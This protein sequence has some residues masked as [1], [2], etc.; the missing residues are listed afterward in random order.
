MSKRLVIVESPAKC[1]TILKYLGKDYIVMASLGHVRDLPTFRLGV[2]LDNNFQPTYQDLKDKKKVIK[3]LKATAKKCEEI[4]IATDPDR[5][6]EAIA[7]HIQEAMKS[8]KNKFKRI[9]FN[10]ITKNAVQSAI[11]DPRDINLNLVNAQQARRILDRLI[12]YKLSPI[13]SKKIRKGLSAGRVQSVSAKLVCD[14]EEE[15]SKFVPVE[16]W[17]ITSELK[18]PDNNTFIATLFAENDPKN[19]LEVP[20]QE[21]A[22]K[23]VE[24]L[25][26]SE[27]SI[28]SI[29]KKE[30]NRNPAPPFITSTLQQ[31]ASRKLNWS[32][33]KT[34][35]V[36]QQ[37]YEG[38]DVDGEA[39][40]LITYMRTD[41]FRISNEARDAAKSYIIKKY[42]KDYYPESPRFYK[43][44]KSAQD[45]HEAIRPTYFELSPDTVSQKTTSDQAK[46]YK[47]IWDRFMASQ[48]SSAK[49]ERTT[50][51]TECAPYFLKTTGNILLFNGF[52]VLYE[53][54]KDDHD[55]DEKNALLPSITKEDSLSLKEVDAQQKFTQPPARYTEAS[56]I[57]EMEEQGI[58][59]PSTY[60]PTLS[61]IQDRGYVQKENKSLLPTELGVLVNGKLLEFFSSIIDVSFTSDMENKLDEIMEGKHVWQEIL[62]DF[63]EPFSAMLEKANEEMEKVNLD[64]PS[65]EVCEK[66]NSPMVIKSGRFGDFLACTSFPDCKNTKSILVELGVNCPDCDSPLIEKKTKRGKPFYGCSTYPKCKFA[67]WTKPVNKECPSCKNPIMTEKKKKGDTLS[68]ICPK[69]K[70]ETEK[71]D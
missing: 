41:S 18:T 48:M 70:H 26:S 43:S 42:C 35:I 23:V 25:K 56:L 67:L 30:V 32:T 69:C 16:Y 28:Y 45:A 10:E 36:A 38:I 19:K 39:T 2:D 49:L 27:Y 5:E 40:G 29:E 47:L 51:I 24:T 17:V 33:K 31:D 58:G 7:W 8:D 65:D 68:Y 44:K 63:Y 1:K 9:V 15:I 13:L 14:R 11:K 55:K 57:K 22:D 50:I 53:E 59:R 4:L 3:E 54:G 37:L 71:S 20:N 34:M 60:A 62:Q 6:G 21:M 52:L 61:I 12:G 66:C 64:R 46:L